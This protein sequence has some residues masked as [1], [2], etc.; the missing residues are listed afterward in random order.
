MDLKEENNPKP[1]SND[2]LNAPSHSEDDFLITKNDPE[3][4]KNCCNWK[5]VLF[6]VLFLV[7]C[8]LTYFLLIRT[9]A[10]KRFSLLLFAKL[11]ELYLASPILFVLCLLVI[12]LV[13]FVFVLPSQTILT[14]MTYSALDNFLLSFLL[15]EAISILSSLLVYVLCASSLRP[16]LLRKMGDNPLFGA[17]KSHSQRKPWK[18]AFLARFLF[19]S[20]GLKDYVLGLIHNPFWPY[21]LSAMVAHAVFALEVGMI[22]KEIRD[23]SAY[24]DG[25]PRGWKKMSWAERVSA[26]FIWILILFTISLSVFLG[27]KARA[28]LRK[29]REDREREKEESRDEAVEFKRLESKV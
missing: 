6:I 17:L 13:S 20:V 28:I 11:R 4:Q 24:I 12:F 5:I 19:I 16:W 1:D 7:C 22:Q 2:S 14:F 29:R 8:V 15:V 9:G 23:F 3:G 18:T 21:T 27:F 26:V 10:L 25:P